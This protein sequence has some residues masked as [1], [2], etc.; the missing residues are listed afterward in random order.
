MFV[1][2]VEGLNIPMSVG[3]P[4]LDK[5]NAGAECVVYDVVI[6][7]NVS[8]RVLYQAA[9]YSVWCSDAAILLAYYSR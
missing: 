7:P 5:D 6:N 4:S 3:P 1:T 8:T 9:R 2:Q